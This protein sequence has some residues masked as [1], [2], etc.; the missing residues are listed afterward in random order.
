M[1]KKGKKQQ[2]SNDDTID[3]QEVEDFVQYIAGV[4]RFHVVMDRRYLRR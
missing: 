3:G 4:G 1:Q 2:N